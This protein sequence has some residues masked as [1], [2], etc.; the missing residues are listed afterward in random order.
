MKPVPVMFTVVPTW[1]VRGE[2]AVM[3]GVSV[4]VVLEPETP[5]ALVTAMKPL[6]ASAGTVRVICVSLLTVNTASAPP[7][8][9][10]VAPVKPVPVRTTDWPVRAW[11]GEKEV[12]TGAPVGSARKVKEAALEQVTPLETREMGPEAEPAATLAWIV[13]AS[14][15]MKLDVVALPKRT[16]VVPTKPVPV[17]VTSVPAWPWAGVNE[18]RV[19]VTM[20]RVAEEALPR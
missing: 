14:V 16:A 8:V 19:G 5:R 11:T 6:A 1:P 15:T 17:R 10:P 2:M 9:T 7:T 20:N 4:K 3:V 13:L 18:A 12:R